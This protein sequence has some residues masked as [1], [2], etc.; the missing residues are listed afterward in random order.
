MKEIYFDNSSTTVVSP[1]AARIVMKVMTEDYG[2]PSSMH[3]KG[4]AAE[5]YV[6]EARVKIA[7]TLRAKENEI[8]F[9]SGGSESNNWAL[10]G[11]ALANRRA[12]NTILTSAFEHPAEDI[13]I[14]VIRVDVPIVGDIVAEIRV[15]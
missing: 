6:R 5:K 11:G 2:N 1:E 4:V 9:T 14:T 3:L 7:K 12:G 15:R 10:I 8:Y 13:Q